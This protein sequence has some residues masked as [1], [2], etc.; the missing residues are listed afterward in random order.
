MAIIA[1]W[2]KLSEERSARMGITLQESRIKI[3]NSKNCYML[4][5][6]L[7]NY[8]PESMVCGYFKN[9]DACQVRLKIG[10]KLPIYFMELNV[11]F[12]INL[13]RFR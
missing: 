3:L 8:N 13:G 6:K 11:F 2:G 7:V 12:F 4:T 1:G 5:K 10:V 9:T